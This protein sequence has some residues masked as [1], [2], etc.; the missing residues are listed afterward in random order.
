MISTYG[1]LLIEDEQIK[2]ED[3]IKIYA[4][5]N[6]N[7][8]IKEKYDWKNQNCN[9]YTSRSIRELKPSYNQIFIKIN[10]K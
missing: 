7:E 6:D 3:Y 4:I 1:N 2:F 9:I 5:E 10:D 8:M